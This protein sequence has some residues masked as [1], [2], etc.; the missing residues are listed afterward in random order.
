M[1]PLGRLLDWLGM[2]YTIN[3]CARMVRLLF[4]RIF[5]LI[6]LL[7]LCFLWLFGILLLD[8][9]VVYLELSSVNS[10]FD[11]GLKNEM[12]SIKVLPKDVEIEFGHANPEARQR[13][14]HD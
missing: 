10:I 7:D 3:C 1:L 8:F 12:L 14:I 5:W 13:A 2:L 6:R 4:I 11:T 9:M